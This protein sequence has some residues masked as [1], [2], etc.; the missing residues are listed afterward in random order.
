[1]NNFRTLADIRRDYGE[2]S[3]SEDSASIDPIAQFKLWFEDVLKNEKNDPTAMVISTVDEKGCPDSRVVLLKGLQEG[4][5]HQLSKC[6]SHAN[7]K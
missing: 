5:L 3:L 1:M 6:Q 7:S 4:N 2:L